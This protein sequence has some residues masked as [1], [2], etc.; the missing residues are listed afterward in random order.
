LIF[1]VKIP[2][3]SLIRHFNF[4]CSL[5]PSHQQIQNLYN[6]L[7]VQSDYPPTPPSLSAELELQLRNERSSES[8]NVQQW[9]MNNKELAKNKQFV[10]MFFLV[11]SVIGYYTIIIAKVMHFDIS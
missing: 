11:G 4:S 5:L 10:L 8:S 3:L 2:P 9:F 7:Q 1:K 6:F